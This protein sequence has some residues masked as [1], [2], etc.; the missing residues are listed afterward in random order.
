LY[1]FNFRT[2]KRA[3]KSTL[4]YVILFILRRQEMTQLILSNL[5]ASITNLKKHPMATVA[6]A[7]GETLAILN[8]NEPVFL[9]CTNK[10][11]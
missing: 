11:V 2:F 4:K 6:S 5:A 9:L 10:N 3:L 1:E 7:E 8:R